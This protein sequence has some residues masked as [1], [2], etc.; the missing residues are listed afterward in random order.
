MKAEA[1]IFQR[2]NFHDQ[3]SMD[4]LPSGKRTVPGA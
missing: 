4:A 1:S 3:R 2:C